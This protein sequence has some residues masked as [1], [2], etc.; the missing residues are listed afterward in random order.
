MLY[1]LALV[2]FGVAHFVYLKET[3]SLVPAWLPWPRAWAM[4]TGGACLAAA[5][6]LLAGVRARLAAVLV[7][8]QI[9]GVTV[10][11]WGPV[12]A[13]GQG[14]ASAWSEGV[15]SLALTAAACVMAARPAP[16]ASGS[17]RAMGRDEA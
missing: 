2:P 13:S 1:G 16:P 7:A 10:L 9:G 3:V 6:A 14:D 12:L 11:V 4:A 8:A 15:I 5:L 17:T